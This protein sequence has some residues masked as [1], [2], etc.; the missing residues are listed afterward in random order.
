MAQP[1]YEVLNRGLTDAAQQFSLFPNV[2]AINQGA[3]ILERIEE[4]QGTVET[5]FQSLET[6]LDVA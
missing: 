6:R 4:L 5:S 1:N 3:R 2:P